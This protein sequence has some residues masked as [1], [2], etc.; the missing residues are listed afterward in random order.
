[1]LGPLLILFT[2]FNTR[3]SPVPTK[4][5]VVAQAARIA[6]RLLALLG[7]LADRRSRSLSGVAT[8]LALT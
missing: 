4:A 8:S 2:I 7:S 5:V 1:M 6:L 3:F